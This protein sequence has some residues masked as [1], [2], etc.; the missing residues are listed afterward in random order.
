MTSEPD[1]PSWDFEAFAANQAA[2]P[3]RRRRRPARPHPDVQA[4]SLSDGT[5]KMYQRE[6]ARF[7]AVCN[8]AGADYLPAHPLTVAMYFEAAASDGQDEDGTPYASNTFN[9]WLAAIDKWHELAGFDKPSKNPKVT[10]TM[11]GIRRTNSGEV[12]RMPALLLEGLR[13]LVVT[14]DIRNYPLAIH[15][16]RDYAI[17]VMGFAV[18]SAAANSPA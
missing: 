1:E 8:D 18:R 9:G 5:R 17:I 16:V 6:W 15:G 10:A 2:A 11:A 7:V 12:R 13:A 4:Q 14:I 3:R